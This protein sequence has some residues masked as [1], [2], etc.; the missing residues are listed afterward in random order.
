V[1][2]AA[3][4]RFAERVEW[5]RRRLPGQE[6]LGEGGGGPVGL[7]NLLPA[8]DWVL[9]QYVGAWRAWSTVTPVV[10]PGHDDR[11]PR[12]AEALLRRAFLQAGLTPEL[13]GGIADLDWRPVGFRPGQDLARHYVPPDKL[14]GPRYHVRVRFGHPVRGPLAVGAGRYRGFG[15]FALEAPE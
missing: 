7:L 15:V 12:K 13:V 8:S 3:P 5:V 9:R 2:V 11:D 1:L 14:V 10:W 4:A 6:L